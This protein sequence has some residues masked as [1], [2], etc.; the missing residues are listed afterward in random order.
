MP[1]SLTN[2]GVV[3]TSGIEQLATR[4][5]IKHRMV[6]AT[7]VNQGLPSGGWDHITG[8]EIDMG[9]PQKST[10]WYRCEWYTDTDDW[11]PSNGGSGYA[12]YRW[13]PSSGWN[14]ILD[15]GWHANY[16]NNNGDF[17][18]TVRTLYFAPVHQSHPGEP[19]A[20]R[21]YGRRHPDVDM[22]CN[23]SI[24]ADLRQQNWNNALFEVW[25]MDGDI[26]TTPNL[27]RY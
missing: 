4:A 1:T 24:G 19:H 23:S 11:G 14:R 15:S 13:T 21:I 6:G 12:L 18:T 25:E 27:T 10:N 9:V 22:R 8:V 17:Y 2:T 26:A 7:T 3:Y 5:V 20:F 16:D